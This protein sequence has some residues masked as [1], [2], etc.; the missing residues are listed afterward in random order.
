[1][2]APSTFRAPRFSNLRDVDLSGL[3]DGD[4]PIWN[5]STGK[6]EAGASG[7]VQ[8]AS[9]G[10]GTQNRLQVPNASQELIDTDWFVNTN[11]LR[12]G[13]V[14]ANNWLG[15]VSN[16]LTLNAIGQVRLQGGGTTQIT[17]SS[18][19]G[20][21]VN[22]AGANSAR[23]LEVRDNSGNPQRRTAYDGTH[24]L[25][26]YVD[27]TGNVVTLTTTGDSANNTYLRIAASGGGYGQWRFEKNGANQFTYLQASTNHGLRLHHVADGCRIQS[28]NT[29][30][31]S[32]GL[33][34]DGSFKL[35]DAA[36]DVFFHATNAEEIGF[37]GNTPTANPVVRYGLSGAG[38]EDYLQVADSSG[39]LINSNWKL[40][41]VVDHILDSV[42][43]TMGLLASTS[44]NIYTTGNSAGTLKSRYLLL[45]TAF[46][47]T[48]AR[49]LHIQDNSG[50]PQVRVAYDTSNYMERYVAADGKITDTLTGTAANT[51][52]LT[53]A[54]QSLFF[55][56]V[57]GGAS[58]PQI[59]SS[60]HLYLRANTGVYI[61]SNAT[62]CMAL[63]GPYQ[64]IY[65][66][67]LFDQTLTPASASAS[68]VQGHI[69]WDANY[70]Y[71]CTATNT[72]KRAA[73]ATW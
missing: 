13:G 61:N 39:A 58:K 55:E 46:G 66:G 68:G 42:N 48:P 17:N 44:V 50:N 45:S 34:S 24:Y 5:A 69:T 2:G 26:E 18:T 63:T 37:F 49:P 47:T 29:A 53:G 20:L 7:G 28:T 1:M 30:H 57:G 35:R 4:A 16:I 25:E 67:V 12:Y 33:D 43:S 6:W 70:I 14:T 23:M 71:V 54:G 60:D 32:L 73:L 22:T 21:G 62:P 3:S 51:Y 38:T 19:T 41:S 11:T 9:S 64:R 36:G 52:T 40:N 15:Y 56:L 65:G 10:A 72:W 27:A 8:Y 59:R 31:V